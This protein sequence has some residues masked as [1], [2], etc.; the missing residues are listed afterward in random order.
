MVFL[1]PFDGSPAA[2]AALRRAVEHGLALERSVLAVSF[3]PTGAEFA[4]RR[5]WIEPA[6]DFAAEEAA[7][8]LERKIDETTDE[9]ELVYDETSAGSPVDGIA[10]AVRQTAQ[11]VGAETLF[12]GLQNGSAE[13]LETPFGS[14][15]ASADYDV[16]IVRGA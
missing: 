15:S 8:A 12:V 3:V 6:D 7:A 9:T 5:T 1:V 4:Q 16:H 2:K 11:D 13:A 10:A 14:I